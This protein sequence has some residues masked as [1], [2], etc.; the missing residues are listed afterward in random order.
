M[1]MDDEETVA[2]IAGGHTF[3]KTHGAATPDGNVGPEPEAAP[4]QQMGLGWKNS[5]APVPVTTPSPAASRVPGRRPRSRG[6]KLLRHLVPL[7]VGA[8]DEPG[9]C[10]PV[11]ADR[12]VR[13]RHGA[14]PARF[15]EVAHAGDAHL[16][17]SL[18]MDPAYEVISRRFA[19]DPAA[20]ADAFARAWFKADSPRHG[21]GDALSRSRGARRATHLAGPGAAGGAQSSS[22]PPTSQ[23]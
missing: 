5:T 6:T 8:V 9:R 17:L 11:G 3:G 4:L 13:G 20:F 1:A 19:E 23:S 22:S 7:R 2:L 12:P 10:A 14:G 15:V 21:T 18:R 16:D